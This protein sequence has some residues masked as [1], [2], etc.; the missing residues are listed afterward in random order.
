MQHIIQ[1]IAMTEAIEQAKRESDIAR[2]AATARAL[3]RDERDA[4]SQQAP[5]P[6]QYFGFLPRL[7]G[8]PYSR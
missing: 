4:A 8:Y 2:H 5:G 7:T 1:A 3:R 6:R